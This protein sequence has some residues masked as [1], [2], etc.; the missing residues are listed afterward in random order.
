MK[1]KYKL[2]W[3]GEVCAERARKAS[4]ASSELQLCHFCHLSQLLT[5]ATSKGIA[6]VMAPRV[7]D[8]DRLPRWPGHPFL[9]S[10]PP[11]PPG[12]PPFLPPCPQLRP[13]GRRVGN[14]DPGLGMCCTVSPPLAANTGA[15]LG[16]P[17]PSPAPP[18]RDCSW[19]SPEEHGEG[20]PFSEQMAPVPS[21]PPAALPFSGGT[22][23]FCLPSRGLWG[24]L[25]TAQRWGAQ[26]TAKMGGAGWGE[27]RMS[28][29]GYCLQPP[30]LR[31]KGKSLRESLP[32]CLQTAGSFCFGK[33]QVPQ[34]S[35]LWQHHAAAWKGGV[36]GAVLPSLSPKQQPK[37]C[38]EP[39]A[40]QLPHRDTS[41]TKTPAPQGWGTTH[42]LAC[43]RREHPHRPVP[44]HP[45][46]EGQ[47]CLAPTSP[48]PVCTIFRPSS[49]SSSAFTCSVDG[50]EMVK[51]L[52]PH[53]PRDPPRDRANGCPRQLSTPRQLPSSAKGTGMYGGRPLFPVLGK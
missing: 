52:L 11:P 3:A 14:R 2:V 5:L 49:A 17:S 29:A 1:E 13:W 18:A 40:S 37:C 45:S 26:A 15:R 43:T 34:E 6:I 28:P 41:L 46:P 44:S 27:V 51:G 21:L 30:S 39:S 4:S 31:W 36:T 50:E 8:G 19:R 48:T 25:G 42:F 9:S 7:A 35:R 20:V 32:N 53:H 47:A 24:A 10:W 33:S 22:M 38:P 16:P 23:A 12:S